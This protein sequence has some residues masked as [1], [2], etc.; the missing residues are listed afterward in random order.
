MFINLYICTRTGGLD[1]GVAS[2]V[3]AGGG[4]AG[5]W[6]ERAIPVLSHCPST[7]KLTLGWCVVIQDADFCGSTQ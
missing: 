1:V 3:R 2:A 7:R 5:H 4:A 6:Q